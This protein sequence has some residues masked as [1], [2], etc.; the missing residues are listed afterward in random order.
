[1]RYKL[2]FVIV[3]IQMN[4]F[5]QS[6]TDLVI[7]PFHQVPER[8]IQYPLKD[9]KM[10]YPDSLMKIARSNV[11]EYSSA[12]TVRNKILKNADY[13][14]KFE[15]AALSKLITSASVPRA[16][17]LS[18]VGCPVH[19]DAIFNVAGKYPWIVNPEHPLQ[20]KCPIG[21]EVYPSNDYVSYYQSGFTKKEG[22]DTKYV[23]DGWGWKSSSGERYWFIAYANQWM[24]KNH[25]G[26]GLTSLGQAYLLTGEAKY[27]SKAIEMLYQIATVYPSMDYENQ[28]RYGLMMKQQKKRYRGKV[29]NLIWETYL[30]T[31]FAEVYDMVWDRI[32]R[33][34]VLQRRIGKSGEEIRSFIEANLLEDG[35]DGV[36]QGKIHGNFGMHQN[37][38][39]TLH[40]SRQNADRTEAINLLINRNSSS[41]STSGLKY[42]MYNQIKR[43]GIPFESPGY[44]T[45]WVERMT[46]IAEKLSKMDIDLFG[47]KRLKKLI[48]APLDMVAI[49]LYTPDV[50]DGGSVMGGIVG[51]NADVYQIAYNNYGEDKYLHWL[52]GSKG[53]SFTSFASLF[54]KPLVSIPALPDNRV[55]K[56]K[57]SH[58]FAGYGLGIL[59][60]QTDQT[61][62]SLTYGMHYSHYHWD[63][64]NFEI[65]ANGQKMMPDLGYPDAMNAFVPGIYSWSTNTVSHNTVVVD[66]KRQQRNLPGTLHEFA[67]GSFARVMDASSPA[68]IDAKTYRRNIIMVD[69]DNEQS[70]FVDFFNLIGGTRH[71]Y[72]LHGPPGE[73]IH[74]GSQWSDTLSGTFAGPNVQAGWMYD[75]DKLRKEGHLTGYGAY[76][77]SGYQHLFNVQQLKSGNGMLEF[78]H[79]RDKDARLRIL[80]LPDG[81]QDVFIADAYDKPRGKESILK[82]LIA[83]RKSEKGVPL[84][85][86]FVSVLAPYKGDKSLFQSAQLIYPDCGTGHVAVINRDSLEEVVIYDPEGS[87]KVLNKYDIETDAVR[88]VATFKDGKLTRLFFNEGSYFRV[89][90]KEFK[91]EEIRGKVVSVDAKTGTFMVELDNAKKYTHENVEHRIAHFSNSLRTTVHPLEKFELMDG[92]VKIIT[93]D[94]LL[95]GRLSITDIEDGQLK[96]NTS[97]SFISDYNGA[98][99][100][101]NNFQSIGTLKNIHNGLITLKDNSNIKSVSVGDDAWICNIGIGDDFLIKSLFTCTCN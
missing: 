2:F 43:D 54:R 13:W 26:P 86:T 41:F 51:K 5:A 92:K 99:L 49:G 22:W 8:I 29:L 53:K 14:L 101:D 73:V 81:H 56:P 98:T 36:I 62:V 76:R 30:I 59:N 44:N 6:S 77:G 75:N 89:K 19:G 69:T 45:I 25:I 32:D 20:V 42:A 85:S 37:A 47:E 40:L 35:I 78:R 90:G 7:P 9:R 15:S 10:I 65:F 48:D 79:I 52:N 34:E 68:Y 27:A 55:V 33:E 80:L 3:V 38:L 70:Y 23:D 84:K 91:S 17:D 24:W 82:Y 28:S 94:D 63:F 11:T 87:K 57:P 16:F 96:T 66:S 31:N 64:L 18:T 100:L 21:G 67:E 46:E 4:L 93:Q 95:I 61:A 72:S 71:D 97:M 83:S 60:N 74:L 39:I 88:V 50:G 58:L 1:M 12:K